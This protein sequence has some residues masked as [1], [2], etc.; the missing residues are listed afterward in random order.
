M[1]IIQRSALVEYTVE[2]MFDLVNDIASYPEFMQGCDSAEV[3]EQSEDCLIG[4]LSL[5]KGGVSQTFTTRNSLQRPE[6]I[7][8]QLV[9]GNFSSFSARWVFLPLSDAASKIS[10]HMVFEFKP[11]LVDMTLE[12][13]LSSAANSLVDSLVERAKQVYG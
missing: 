5:S 7:T 2:Q 12:K 13:M 3:L 9:E 6:S 1:A 11:G 10:L 4:K 8:M